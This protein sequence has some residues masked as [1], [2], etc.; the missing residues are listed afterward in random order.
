MGSEIERSEMAASRWHIAIL[1][2][3]KLSRFSGP[4]RIEHVSFLRIQNLYK[5]FDRVVAVNRINL[6][7]AEGEFF[8]LLGS[9]GCGKT[10][11]LR[12]VGG[13]EKPDG[14][15]IY[16]GD[17][18]LVSDAQKSVR[19]TGKARHGHGFSILRAVAAYDG[20]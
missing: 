2:P 18:C 12:M 7:I 8:T 11:T 20:L 13:L 5:T 16:L 17:Q 6:E 19:Q 10:T 15:A 9:S 4:A 3:T 14:G 1:D